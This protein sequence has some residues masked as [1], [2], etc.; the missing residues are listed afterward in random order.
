MNRSDFEGKIR[1]G[2]YIGAGTHVPQGDSLVPA[3]YATAGPV[4]FL[5][6]DV[7]NGLIV[8]NPNGGARSDVTP[9]AAALVAGCPGV[10]VGDIIFAQLINGSAGAADAENIT[11]T[12]GAGISFDANQSAQSRIV[13]SGSSKTLYFRFTNVTLGSEAV[14][15]YC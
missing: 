9:T 10:Q 1:R 8:R 6:S 3:S 14:T 5:A 7:Y 11:I 12:A 2:R 13:R 15:L 4:T